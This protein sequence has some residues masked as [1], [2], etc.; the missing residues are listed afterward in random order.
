[1]DS[2]D[3]RENHPILGQSC[4]YTG[5]VFIVKTRYLSRYCKR[6]LGCGSKDGVSLYTLGVE[7]L[8][9][10]G[11]PKIQPVSDK[12]WCIKHEHIIGIPR[13][14]KSLNI[15]GVSNKKNKPKN[16]NDVKAD[17]FLQSYEWRKLRLE[18][19]LKHGRRC[20]CCGATPD[21]GAIMN[22]DHIK[23]RKLF[24]SL[25]LDINNLQVLC[26]ECN[27]GKGNWNQTDFR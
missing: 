27:H 9:K 8:E 10:D 3:K 20:Q 6:V 22:V 5:E 16:K 15:N 17:S 1:M 7:A 24:P 2:L 21:T 4:F 25:A 12:N 23:P 19:F 13:P 11:Y 14:K 18:V 26:H